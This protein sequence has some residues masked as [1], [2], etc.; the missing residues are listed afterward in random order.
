MLGYLWRKAIKVSYLMLLQQSSN[1][2]ASGVSSPPHAATPHAGVSSHAG[3]TT[4]TN[5][6]PAVLQNGHHHVVFSQGG[7][8]STLV[9]FLV[10]RTER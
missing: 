2:V 9:S 8:V 7:M 6:G 4:L 5:A 1:W 10:T 3:V